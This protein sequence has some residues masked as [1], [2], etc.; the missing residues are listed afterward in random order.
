MNIV[1]IL[2]AAIVPLVLGFI[3]YN[4]K[5]FGSIWMK[6]IGVDLETIQ[7]QKPNM[8]KLLLSALIFAFMIA[9]MLNPMVIHQ[10]S[11]VATR[12]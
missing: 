7:N 9:F 10:M 4:P 11:V 2:V 8:L 5:V 1:A 6:E 3:W 12:T